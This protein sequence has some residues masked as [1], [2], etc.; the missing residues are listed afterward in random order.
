[1]KAFLLAAGL[2]TRLRPL[3]NQLPKC[4]VPVAGKPMLAYWFDLFRKNGI[5]EVLI[6]L[7]HFPEQVTNYVNEHVK[8]IQVTLVYE[9]A[10][11]GSLGTILHNRAYVEN[12]ESFF[13]F[14]SDT[15]TNVDIG[16][17]LKL[18]IAS[19][20]PLTMGLFHA[21]EPSACGI[22]QMDEKNIIIDFEEKP[23][24][25]KSTLANAGMY[26]MK[27][28]LLDSI[29]IPEGKLLDIGYDLLP[30]MVNNM[31]GFEIRDFV[32]DIGT[33]GNLALANEFVSKNPFLFS[34]RL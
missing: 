17:M 10:L 3:T 15:L 12:E 26:I 28:G 16:S 1:M 25:P 21:A 29:H 6:N 30:N 8:D 5:T 14:Y 4:L 18:H 32:L 22:V 19:G 13:V 34:V 7:N 11:L 33:P 20:K 24:K 27:P 9:E 2:G 23:P 31:T